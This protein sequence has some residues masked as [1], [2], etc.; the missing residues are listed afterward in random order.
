[1]NKWRI[2]GKVTLAI[3]PITTA[4]V[5][6]AAGNPLV[7]RMLDKC[8]PATFNAT[9]GPGTC[10]G[11]GTITFEHFIKEVTAAHKAGVWNFNPADGTVDPGTALSLENRG[12]ETHTFTKVANFGGGFS[13]IFKQT[14][15]VI[16]N[17][18][19]I[20]GSDHLVKG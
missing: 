19:V 6:M 10:V 8:D 2:C 13:R 1:M 5:L 14:L 3:I 18:E 16:N 12:G 17:N 15:T 20:A 7:V 9:I 11:N 4:L